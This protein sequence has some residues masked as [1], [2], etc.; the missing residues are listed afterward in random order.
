MGHSDP[1]SL[2]NASLPEQQV[3]P[4]YIILHVKYVCPR[5]QQVPPTTLPPNCP[6]HFLFFDVTTRCG[7]DRQRLVPGSGSTFFLMN[8]LKKI[9][10]C[11]PTA[12]PPTQRLT[13]YSLTLR[14]AATRSGS[15]PYLQI[16]FILIIDLDFGNMKVDDGLKERAKIFMKMTSDVESMQET[17]TVLF[18]LLKFLY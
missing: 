5:V 11:L 18:S 2:K 4:A 13:P 10:K 8:L 9:R 14:L 1:T 16:V 12:C 17:P 7:S 3:P 6:A 15:Q